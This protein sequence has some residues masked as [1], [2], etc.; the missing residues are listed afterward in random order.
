[1]GCHSTSA[2]LPPSARPE[3][4]CVNHTAG[5]EDL[6]LKDAARCLAPVCSC[7]GSLVLAQ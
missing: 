2:A 5:E 1:M 3:V 6:G 4:A 7:C